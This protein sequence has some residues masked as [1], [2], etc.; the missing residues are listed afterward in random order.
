M[1][2]AVA[3]ALRAT[4]ILLRLPGAGPRELPVGRTRSGPWRARAALEAPHSPPTS[5]ALAQVAHLGRA[6]TAS[7][8][9]AATSRAPSSSWPSAHRISAAAPAI[10]LASTAEQG[11]PAGVGASIWGSMPDPPGLFYDALLAIHSTTGL[12]WASTLLLATVMMRLSM[13]PL[14]VYSDRNSRKVRRPKA[15]E[16]PPLQLD[17]ARARSVKI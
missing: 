13:L 15:L 10:V 6:T 12:G 14:S 1:R 9:A 3:P 4:A 11:E 17:D 8:A 7:P 16:P 2:R 5:V